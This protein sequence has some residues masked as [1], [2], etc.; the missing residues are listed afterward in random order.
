M[1]A[2]RR[3]LD[4]AERFYSWL[5]V[6][7]ARVELADLERRAALLATAE[8][9]VAELELS[10]ALGVDLRAERRGAGGP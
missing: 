7:A 5:Q 6:E 8:E 2:I 1:S 10:A 9:R 4:E 3:I